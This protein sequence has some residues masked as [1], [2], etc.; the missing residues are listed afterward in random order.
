[1]TMKTSTETT[2]ASIGFTEEESRKILKKAEVRT[3]PKDA[4]VSRKWV[5]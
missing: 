3:F 1:M 5:P 4:V 2:L